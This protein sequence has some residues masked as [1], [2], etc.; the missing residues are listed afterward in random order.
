M[1]TVDVGW[2]ARYGGGAGTGGAG[3]G[4]GQSGGL[5]GAAVERAQLKGAPWGALRKRRG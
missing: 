4:R 2:W 3:L 1:V 5:E